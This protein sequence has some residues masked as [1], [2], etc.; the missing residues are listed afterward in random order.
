MRKTARL[1]PFELGALLHAHTHR[2]A[3]SHHFGW[4]LLNRL[5]RRGFLKI[6]QKTSWQFLLT[7]LGRKRVRRALGAR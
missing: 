2:S 3:F 6:A 4:D 5:K 1:T 7:P